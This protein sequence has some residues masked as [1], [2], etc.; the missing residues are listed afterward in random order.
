MF[1]RGREPGAIGAPDA[2]LARALDEGFIP[3][4]NTLDEYVSGQE[5]R[6]RYEKLSAWRRARGHIWVG[7]GPF[8]LHS[9]YP[10]EKIVVIRRS[11]LFSDPAQKWVRF[12]EP[13]IAEVEVS[14]PR[15][16]K[17]GS[18]AEFRVEVTF[19]GKPYPVQDVE[20]VR[21]L[22]FD[23]RGEL[24]ELANA[25]E[26]RE[27]VW[28]VMLTRR[29]TARLVAGSNRL[30]LVVTPRVVAVPSFKTFW[31]VTLREEVS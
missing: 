4:R 27:G 11:D 14:G 26:V 1:L 22:L 13:R 21:F 28:R 25:E 5:A 3:Y 18:A 29:Q 2:K 31:F 19:Q 30:E 23:A 8:Y 9:V 7:N 10:V 15:M 12:V 24:V 16:I 6:D 20:F 17:V